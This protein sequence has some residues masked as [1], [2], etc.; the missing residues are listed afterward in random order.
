[1]ILRFYDLCSHTLWFFRFFSGRALGFTGKTLI[2]PK[3]IEGANYAFAPLPSDVR[4][5][6]IMYFM[7]CCLCTP[8]MKAAFPVWDD[9]FASFFLQLSILPYPL[10]AS[11]PRVPAPHRCSETCML[12]EAC[13]IHTLIAVQIPS[14]CRTFFAHSSLRCV[15]I[16]FHFVG[17]S[18]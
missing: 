1:M 11:C 14:P 15:D 5:L 2:H 13:V 17:H 12:L 6:E 3:T 7:R 10:L 9:F 4:R 18:G 8:I 16:P